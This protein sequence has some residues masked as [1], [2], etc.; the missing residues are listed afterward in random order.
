LFSSD[1]GMIKSWMKWGEHVTCMREM[2]SVYKVL[3]G[4]P[5]MKRQFGRP[6]HRC[7]GNIEVARKET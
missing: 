1:V 6:K 5:E 7:E 4:K 2:R 3:V